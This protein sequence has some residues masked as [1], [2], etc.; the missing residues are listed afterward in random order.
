MA[1]LPHGPFFVRTL[2]PHC[3]A[4]DGALYDKGEE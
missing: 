1:S 3:G 4:A 2:E